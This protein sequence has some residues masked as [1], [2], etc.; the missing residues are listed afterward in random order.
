MSRE[1]W[2]CWGGDQQ[3]K[4]HPALLGAQSVALV[5]DPLGNRDGSAGSCV[6][7]QI[8]LCHGRNLLLFVLTLLGLGAL[9]KGREG[10]GG[11][12]P[13]SAFCCCCGGSLQMAPLTVSQDIFISVSTIVFSLKEAV[14]IFRVY[15]VFQ[16]LVIAQELICCFDSSRSDPEIK[17]LLLSA[18]VPEREFLRN[19]F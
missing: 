11:C 4:E 6:V 12:A 5:P 14:L 13:F 3:G 2:L 10:G 15:F 8:L 7:A 17:A 16:V 19:S 1:L 9:E 18:D